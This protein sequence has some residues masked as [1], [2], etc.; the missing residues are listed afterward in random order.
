MSFCRTTMG[1]LTAII[2]LNSLEIP[3]PLSRGLD[4]NN[5]SERNNNVSRDHN[6]RVRNYRLGDEAT[7]TVVLA[8]IC[9]DSVRVPVML[10][11]HADYHPG[12]R[13]RLPRCPT[14]IYNLVSYAFRRHAWL[15]QA[16]SGPHY[17]CVTAPVCSRRAPVTSQH[18]GT[19]LVSLHQPALCP[20][21]LPL[22]SRLHMTT[23]LACH[24]DIDRLNPTSS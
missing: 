11:A 1:I 24:C 2:K 13:T 18:A 10:F 15:N 8:F 14:A 5:C 7:Y 22:T 19:A 6:T 20:S 16:N 3:K 4:D 9:G 23:L 12:N 17:G 21:P